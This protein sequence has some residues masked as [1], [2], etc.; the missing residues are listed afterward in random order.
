MKKVSI[1]EAIKT[2]RSQIRCLE[3]RLRDVESSCI[4]AGHGD[5]NCTMVD[6]PAESTLETA[7]EPLYSGQFVGFEQV[8]R[9]KRI[10]A[11]ARV[12]VDS[13][14]MAV[15]SDVQRIPGPLL[16]RLAEVLEP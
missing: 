6:A 2:V 12:L 16:R 4:E 10:E 9:W 11:A 15:D 14:F 8:A 13:R 5:G 1:D 7:P 3:S